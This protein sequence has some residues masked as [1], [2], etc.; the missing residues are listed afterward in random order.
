MLPGPSVHPEADLRELRVALEFF[1]LAALAMVAV[2]LVRPSFD[3]EF[4]DSYIMYRYIDNLA[5]GKGLVFNDGDHL[6][7]FSS[8]TWVLILGT[9][10]RFVNLDTILLSKLFGVFCFGSCL[11]GTFLATNR[12]L[13]DLPTGDARRILVTAFV[14]FLPI[15]VPS[16]TLWAV[17][18]LENSLYALALIVYV[19]FVAAQWPISAGIAAAFVAATRVEGIMFCVVPV[20]LDLLSLIT[21]RDF[22]RRPL[23]VIR[24]HFLV[25]H[26]RFYIKYFSIVIAYVVIITA[27]RLA[28]FQ[29]YLPATAHF[30]TPTSASSNLL[31]GWRY[32]LRFVSENPAFSILSGAALAA[33][34]IWIR[35]RFVTAAA[36]VVIIQLLFAIWVGGDWMAYHRFFAAFIPLASIP[37]VATLAHLIARYSRF[38]SDRLGPAV[39]CAVAGFFVA[40]DAIRI[41]DVSAVTF[42]PTYPIRTVNAKLGVYLSHNTPPNGVVA[43][44]DVGAIAYYSQRR[45]IDLHGLMDRTLIKYVG[46]FTTAPHSD[47]DTGYVLAQHPQWIIAIMNGPP[48]SPAGNNGAYGLY[49]KLLRDP[50]FPVDYKHYADYTLASF[51]SYRLFYDARQMVAATVSINIQN[52]AKEAETA[53]VYFSDSHEPP[54]TQYSGEQKIVAKGIFFTDFRSGTRLRVDP[55]TRPGQRITLSNFSIECRDRV[56]SGF[57]DPAGLAGSGIKIVEADNDRVIL[58]TTSAAPF[59]TI[60]VCRPGPAG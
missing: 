3:F 2:W 9:V 34:P 45:I 51:Y 38:S 48:G 42:G 59:L 41:Y 1:V 20:A 6:E 10:R 7:G 32:L 22:L 54:T 24:R 17:G 39:I 37:I 29:D 49:D 4:D 27:F 12:F 19:T 15:I 13:V 43:V 47:V 35:N 28:Y 30:K 44:G 36:S 5:A 52:D 8:L 31:A 40:R 11:V 26:R 60:P 50:R 18:G 57:G 23:D 21:R 14:V 53:R 25:E 58:E 46:N 55:S 33:F 16:A 56:D